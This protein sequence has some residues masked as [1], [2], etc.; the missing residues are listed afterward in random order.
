MHKTDIRPYTPADANE[1]FALIKREGIEWTYWQDDNWI[2]YQKLLS[3]CVN[4]IIFED[5]QLCGYVRGRNDGGF[6]IYIYDLLVDKTCRGKEYGRL[7]ME[8]VCHDFPCD[9]I[10]VLSDVNP[11]YE[12]LGYV[13]EGTVFI[14][15]AR[16]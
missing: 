14:V 8:K 2:K 3:E 1:L 9:N 12:K 6:G 11:Y 10:Y 4:Y 16:V 13:K 5:G 15:K 7:L